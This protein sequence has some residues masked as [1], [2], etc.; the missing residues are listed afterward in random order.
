MSVECRRPS[1]LN[2]A[3]TFATI[4]ST[5]FGGGQKASVRQQVLNHGWMD[6][7]RFMDG[8]E[9]AQVLPGPNILNLA[10]YCGQRVRGIPGAIAAFIGASIPPFIIV[11]IAGA[12]YFKFSTNPYVYGGLR[13]CAA[14]A[15][16][17]TIGN[18]LELTWDERTEWVR[19]VLVA[20]TAVAVSFLK[21]PLLLVLVV[22]GGIGIAREYIRS[23]EHSA[24]PEHR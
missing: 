11:L 19:I 22:F 18:A 12:L 1:L 3:L 14:G 17:L 23:R 8:L 2:V 4:S 5:A 15:L 10:L 21:M 16:G 24:A 7:E 9:I 6:S 20:V 13:G